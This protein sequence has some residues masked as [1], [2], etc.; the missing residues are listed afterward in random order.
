MRPVSPKVFEKGTLLPILGETYTVQHTYNSAEGSFMP[1]LATALA[2]ALLRHADHTFGLMGNGNAHL[3]DALTKLG[4]PFSEVRHEVATVASADA[5]ARVSGKLA[6]ATATYGAGYTNTLTALAEAARAR[7][8]LL[9]VVGDAPT[10][11]LRVWDIDQEMAAAAVGVRTYTVTPEN[12]DE[13]VDR[14]AAAAERRRMPVVIAIPYDLV[15]EPVPDSAPAS[16]QEIDLSDPTTQRDLAAATRPARSTTETHSPGKAAPHRPITVATSTELTLAV[17]ALVQAERPIVIAGHGAWLSEAA[18]SLDV[19]ADRLGAITAST[20]LGRGI[21]DNQDFDL[22]I[23][24][25]FGQQAA[26]QVVAAADVVLVVGASLN[27]FT[28]CFGELFGEGTRVIRIDSDQVTPPKTVH[29]IDYQLLRGD[30]QEVLAELIAGIDSVQHK[31]NNWRAQLS[32]LEPGGT[33]RM[34][35]RGDTAADG[36][37]ADGRLDPRPVAARLAELLPEDRHVTTDGGHFIGW[38]NMYWP[39][40]SPERMIMVGTAFQSIGLGFSTVAGVAAAAPDSTVVLN[41]GDGGGL[42]AIADLETTIRTANSC[43]VVVWNDGAYGAEV[44]LYGKMG[45]DEAPMRIPNVNFAGVAAALGATGVRVDTLADLDALTE[46]RAAGARGT[47]VLDCRISTSVVAP[48]QREIQKVN[49]LD[50]D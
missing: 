44:H 29:P 17:Q 9:L 10:A 11:G 21:F 5:Y 4:M 2:S 42:M 12:V 22:G 34:L 23:T 40:A 33:L 30:A 39:V 25:G 50:V 8:P 31:S 26:M 20:A 35:D 45:L 49:G 48:Y 13:V 7:T 28:M 41:T 43:V 24:G 36:L 38:A 1:T 18:A 46:W 16:T 47:I 15:T 27:Q 14:A 32:G 37:C 3:I 6:I 19:I